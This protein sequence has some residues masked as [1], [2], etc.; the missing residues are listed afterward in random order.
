MSGLPGEFLSHCG[1]VALAGL[2]NAGKSTLLN[3]LCGQ[4]IAIATPK[5]QTTRRMIRGIVNG[6]D[7]QAVLLDT[8]GLHAPRNRLGQLMTRMTQEACD[9]ADLVLL[10]ADASRKAFDDAERRCLERTNRNGTPLVVVFNKVDRIQKERLLPRMAE[11]HAGYAPREILPISALTGDG[12]DELLRI[13]VRMLPE[14]PPIF[15]REAFT[16]ETERSLSE[17]IIREHVLRQVRQ[18]IPHGTGVLVASFEEEPLHDPPTGV[19]HPGGTAPDRFV[20]IAASIYC[21]KE[22]HKGILLG[23]GGSMIQ[24]IGTAARLELEE[25]LQ[26]RV[27]LDLHI[28][29]REDWRNRSA[30]LRDLGFRG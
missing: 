2:P 15:D 20:R 8:P 29:V 25:M 5:P 18:E 16:D 23:K 17:E 28:K 3:R 13:L 10:V 26:A 7:H 1:V 19:S 21:E 27:H 30:I 11:A 22:T 12:C 24:A 9:Q 6:P 4:K 14:G